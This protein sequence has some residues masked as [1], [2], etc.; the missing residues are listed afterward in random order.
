MVGAA[1]SGGS[2]NIAGDSVDPETGAT[3]ATISVGRDNTA[4]DMY[5]TVC[6]GWGNTASGYTATAL[7]GRA[8]LAQGDNSL[9]AGQLAKVTHEGAF[10]W[11]DSS[12]YVDFDSAAAHEFAVR[13]TGGARFV[14]AIDGSGNPTNG[15]KV[16]AGAWS[17][18]SD[19]NAKANFTGVDGHSIL[20]RLSSIPV[21]TWNYKSQDP[22][23]RHIGPMAQDFYAAF[24]VGEDDKHITTVDADGV[25]LAAIQ[26]L[27]ELAQEKDAEI[28]AQKRQIATLEERL[29]VLEALV[30]SKGSY[31]L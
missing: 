18:L 10:V 4:S 3:H 6:G 11:A 21:E 14:T 24:G 30:L 23:I 28:S 15:V 13:C 16:T 7:G 1:I 29:A 5:A 20:E 17:S 27:Y 25:A 2:G 19:R 26:G 31:V 12:E 9:A 8:N 22:A